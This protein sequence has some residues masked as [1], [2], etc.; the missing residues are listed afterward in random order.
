MNFNHLFN[1][2]EKISEENK[3]YHK[4]IHNILYFN[5]ENFLENPNF[6]D[7]ENNNKEFFD[8][9]INQQTEEEEIKIQDNFKNFTQEIDTLFNIQTFN[10][11]NKFE[12]LVDCILEI[13]DYKKING[14]IELFEK[15][16]R[17]FDSLKLFKKFKFQKRKICKKS[18]IRDLL[19]TYND[20]DEIMRYFLSNYLLV[21]LVFLE[22]DKY[23]LYCEDDEFEPFKTTIVIYFYDK[24]YYYLS[25][26][27]NN[28]LFTSDD[29]FV[30]KLYDLHIPPEEEEDTFSNS[31]LEIQDMICNINLEPIK[32]EEVIVEEIIE[33]KIENP[34]VVNEEKPIVVKNTLFVEELVKEKTKTNESV[35]EQKPVLDISYNL[36]KVTELKKLCKERKIKGY[37]KLKKKQLIELLNK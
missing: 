3:H 30:T 16:L 11:S 7:Q 24:N 4:E 21:N 22:N 9:N 36:M 1:H 6:L 18:V 2:L 12:S 31:I 17:D 19:L 25:S 15:M 8:I 27:D 28:S 13:I 10:T 5:N 33:E 20:D 37:S 34:L 23:K 35:V 32:K 29:E 26:K 14:K